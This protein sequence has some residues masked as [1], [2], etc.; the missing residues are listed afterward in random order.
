[1]ID[2]LRTNPAESERIGLNLD[3]V[4]KLTKDVVNPKLTVVAS[5]DGA[6]LAKES[7]ETDIGGEIYLASGRFTRCNGHSPAFW[8]WLAASLARYS[9]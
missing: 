3:L 6:K 4:A 5:A 9:L 8:A 1:M 2:S 7:E